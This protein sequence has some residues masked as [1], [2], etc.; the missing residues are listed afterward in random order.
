MDN[1]SDRGSSRPS[2][3]IRASQCH[4]VRAVIPEVP[5]KRHVYGQGRVYPRVVELNA[6]CRVARS[7][8]LAHRIAGHL[9]ISFA[10]VGLLAVI[11]NVI[12]LR[13]VAIIEITRYSSQPVVVQV[14]KPVVATPDE[15]LSPAPSKIAGLSETIDRFEHAVIVRAH[16]VSPESDAQVVAALRDLGAEQANFATG[17]A[18]DR[19][20]AMDRTLRTYRENGTELLALADQRRARISAYA[21]HLESMSDRLDESVNKSWK[22]LGRVLARQTLLRLR[23][24]HDEIQRHFAA[25][26]AADSLVP[27]ALESLVEKEAAFAR[28]LGESERSFVRGEGR[29]WVSAIRSD[30]DEIVTLRESLVDDWQNLDKA[31]IAF[32]EIRVR[33]RDAAQPVAAPAKTAKKA[34]ATASATPFVGPPILSRRPFVG[35][36]L[37]DA[38]EGRAA[39]ELQTR[40]SRHETDNSTRRVVAWLTGGVLFIVLLI[41]IGTVRNI[42]VPIR[43]LL[44]ATSQLGKHGIHEPIPRGGIKELDTL[45]RS[46]NQMAE[47]LVAARRSAEQHQLLLE[48]RVE[49]R[50]RQLQE[51]AEHDPLTGLPN[52]R[53]LLE[54]LEDTLADARRDKRLVAVFFLDLDNFKNVNDSMGHAF[55]D[56]VLKAVSQRL[57]DVARD[58]G[59]AARLGGDEFTVILTA[60]EDIAHVR[61]AGLKVVAAFSEPLSVGT[62][63]LKI[64]VSAG[65]S[66]YPDHEHNAEGLLKAADAALFRAKALGRSQLSIYTPELLSEA[67]ARFATEQGLRRAVDRG[68]FELEFQPEVSADTLRTVLV[69]ALIRWRL[70]DGRLASPAEFLGVA[71]ESGLLAEINDWVLRAAIEAASHWYHGE[72]PEA[73][74]AI[75]VSAR[76]LLDQRFAEKVGALLREFQLPARCIE[77]ELTETVLQTGQ[78]TLDTLYQLH[79]SGIA[80]AL[81]DFGAGYSSLASLEKLPFTRIKLDRSLI[82]DIA[83]SDRSAAIA[84]AII[85]LCHNLKLEVTAEGVETPE[86]L[87]I[88]HQHRPIFLQGFLLAR[89]VPRQELM[90]TMERLAKDVPLLLTAAN[91]LHSHDA[92]STS[93]RTLAIRRIGVA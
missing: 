76:Q 72:W 7:W 93:G 70:P 67:A 85:W 49:E 15:S 53:H 92:P 82:D 50:T 80:I 60:A 1:A 29:E 22:I 8:Q 16:I 68:E 58:I 9:L 51:L 26:I 2:N 62:R 3:N 30:I 19:R 84:R 66:I 87:G 5:K 69:E 21:E 91:I 14:D 86:Q 34:P 57:Q 88:L 65:A 79:A 18:A 64:S 55:G 83:T 78:A 52:R 40:V 54:L 6:I 32:S 11:A 43:R 35:P 28:T 12:V 10:A 71:E 89:A 33:A 45:A 17:V 36:P 61:D 46:F 23:S 39:A 63:D 59:F 27:S 38:S 47:E 44:K 73:R 24:D 20:R 75:N 37:L 77:I 42:V 48:Q 74:V 13:G 41:S 81:D 56:E 4:C 31:K 25:L 90:G